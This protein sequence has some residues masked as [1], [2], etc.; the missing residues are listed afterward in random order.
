MTDIVAVPP[1]R[2]AKEFPVVGDPEFNRKA[3][4]W[5]TEEVLLVTNLYAMAQSAYTNAVASQER[6][7]AAGQFAQAA[8]TDSDLAMGYRN[9]ANQSA[10]TATEKAGIATGAAATA[11]AQADLAATARGD[12]EGARTGAEDARDGSEDACDKAK[13]YRDEAEDFRDQSEVYATRQLKGSSSTSIVPGAG[14][15][16]LAMEPSRSFV[17]GMYVIASSVSDLGTWMSGRVQ[18]YDVGTGALVIGVD[19]YA[20]SVAKADWVIGVAAP[21]EHNGMTRQRIAASTVAVPGVVYVIVGADLPLTLPP[22]SSWQDG[23]P[24]GVRLGVAVSNKQQIDFGDLTV[25]GQPGG[26]RYINRRGY[27]L[28]LVFD[29]LSGGFV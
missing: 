17:A 24:F 25:R 8:A 27:A 9:S 13:Q 23:D 29:S 12:A 1:A 11:T 2:P 3:Y 15:K 10:I 14:A 26:L 22:A 6:A 28:D 16:A 18:S 21:G 7:I 4:D 20:G 5:A 19:A